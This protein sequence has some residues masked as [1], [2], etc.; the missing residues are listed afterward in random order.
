M[1]EEN[2][3]NIVQWALS[4]LFYWAGHVTYLMTEWFIDDHGLGWAAYKTYNALMGWSDWWQRTGPGP[5]KM[6]ETD[7]G[8][9]GKCAP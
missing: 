2:T 9:Y 4:W 7:L 3:P 1:V 8:E 5:W 6:G